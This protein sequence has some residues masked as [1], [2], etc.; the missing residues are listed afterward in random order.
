MK[1]EV[2]EE[3]LFRSRRWQVLSL[4][5]VVWR[6]H[7][8]ASRNIHPAEVMY[9][10]STLSLGDHEHKRSDDYHEEGSLKTGNCEVK[11]MGL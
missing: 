8:A 11:S 7:S 1:P 4:A 5:F 9:C 2:T 6:F 3:V 10:C